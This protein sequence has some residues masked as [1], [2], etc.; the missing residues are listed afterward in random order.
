MFL[1]IWGWGGLGGHS[2]K[3]LTSLTLKPKPNQKARPHSKEVCCVY[4]SFSFS[5]SS[6]FSCSFCFYLS[7][8]ATDWAIEEEKA[9]KPKESAF[10]L[11]LA[12]A[13]SP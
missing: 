12:W 4:K 5:F 2:D 7:L 3:T 6:L 9:N 10:I 8:L 13:S 1:L 11:L